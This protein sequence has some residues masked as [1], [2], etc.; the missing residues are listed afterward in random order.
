MAGVAVAA[1]MLPAA[2][3]PGAP[4]GAAK[5]GTAAAAAA[6]AAGVGRTG[7][8]QMGMGADGCKA[9]KGAACAILPPG[10]YMGGSLVPASLSLNWLNQV[11][12]GQTDGRRRP[13]QGFTQGHAAQLKGGGPA[14]QLLNYGM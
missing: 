9:M 4:C 7:C 1:V 8:A 2:G 5:A 3:T 13:R 10:G 6:P 12:A 11:Q 14:G